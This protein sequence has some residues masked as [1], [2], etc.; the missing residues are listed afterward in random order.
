[1]QVHLHG[2]NKFAIGTP[3][4]GARGKHRFKLT[5]AED[6]RWAGVRRRKR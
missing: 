5:A 4:N 2:D 3:R 6:T 1:M